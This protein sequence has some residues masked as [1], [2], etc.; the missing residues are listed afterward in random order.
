MFAKHHSSLKKIF[1]K[2]CP[3]GSAGSLK[4][5]L[6]DDWLQFGRDF[7]IIDAKLSHRDMTN[8]FCNVQDENETSNAASMEVSGASCTC[9]VG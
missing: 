8:I 2:Y 1:L 5:L 4:F 6:G 3:Q 7:D 9:C